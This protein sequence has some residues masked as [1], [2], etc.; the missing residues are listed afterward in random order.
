MRD[1][2]LST[3]FLLGNWQRWFWLVFWGKFLKVDGKF[4]FVGLSE[5]LRQ[6]PR[7][8]QCSRPSSKSSPASLGPPSALPDLMVPSVVGFVGCFR[9]AVASAGW[10]WWGWLKN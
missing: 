3:T 4:T 1:R 9:G 10:W 5:L 7:P 6:S 8:A 2:N